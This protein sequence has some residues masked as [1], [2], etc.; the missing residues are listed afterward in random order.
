MQPNRLLLPILLSL[1]LAACGSKEGKDA[2][3][4]A[5]PRGKAGVSCLADYVERIGDILPLEVL[6]EVVDLEGATP[7]KK[8][9]DHPSLKGVSWTWPSERKRV[10]EV[11]GMKVETPAHNQ[12]G[13]SGFKRLDGATSGPQDGKT[14]VERNYRS[15][16]TEE[17]EQ[18]QIRMKE[19]IAER[20]RKGELTEEQA[21]MAGG[22]GGNLM[23]QER[24]V[25]SIDGVGDAARWTERDRT[26]A[27]GHKNVVFTLF[28]DVSEDQNL[29][30]QHAIALAKRLLKDCGS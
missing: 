26:L 8:V 22:L 13:V 24:V 2:K 23:G 20:V 30:R 19:Q 1:F 7:E 15:I 14:Y 4:T 9:T 28:V 27:V 29:N 6:E 12:V 10:M 25:E 5:S 3:D 17:M 18:I 16:S 11:M 21:K